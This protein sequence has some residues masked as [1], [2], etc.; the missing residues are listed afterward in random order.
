MSQQDLT[1]NTPSDDALDRMNT[2]SEAA[3]QAY[4]DTIAKHYP[5]CTPCPLNP[6]DA[7][8]F[9]RSCLSALQHWLDASQASS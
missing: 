7:F 4:W 9:D 6:D 5:E 1:P 3:Q 8:A 2:A